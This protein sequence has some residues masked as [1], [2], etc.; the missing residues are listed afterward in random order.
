MEEKP[1]GENG[2][3]E[4]GDLSSEHGS[5]KWSLPFDPDSGERIFP[6]G[7]SRKVSLNYP[8]GYQDMFGRFNSPSDDVPSE[9]PD[10]NNDGHD[11]ID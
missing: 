9:E 11:D 8:G 2:E 7:E 5:E 6:E 1:N 10:E 3:Q 4:D